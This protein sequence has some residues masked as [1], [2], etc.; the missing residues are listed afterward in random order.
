[1]T[2]LRI[3]SSTFWAGRGR[4][5]RVLE[6]NVRA[7]RR[8]WL[9]LVSGFFEPLFYLL[10]IGLGLSHL[11]GR[12]PLGGRSVSYVTYVAP[13]LLAS[14]AMN[15]SILD[16]TFNIFFK[17][18][19]TKV[20]DA[21]L[22]TPLKVRDV[23]IGDLAWALIRGSLYSTTFLVVMAAL[24]LIVSPW[25]I[26]CFPCASLIGFA[27][28]A[29]GMGLTSYMRNW[30]DFDFLFLAIMPLFLFSA[31]FYP[32]GVYPGWLQVIV[33][34]TPLYQG[35]AL[36]R[37]LDGGIVGWPILAHVAYLAAMGSLGLWL[38]TKRLAKLLLP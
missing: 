35:V 9:F 13:G 4:A 37:E 21:L 7:Y 18:K 27:F 23:A 10:S 22:A 25:A 24:G 26:L 2:T 33:T 19:I 15:G 36:L 3:P 29:V 17:P 28:G 14:S 1:M 34:F 6:R 5:R 8:G 38:A 16:A 32:L 12:L 30:Q 31:V 11:V 20:Y